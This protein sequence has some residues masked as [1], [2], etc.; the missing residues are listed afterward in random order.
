M[1]ANHYPKEEESLFSFASKVLSESEYPYNSSMKLIQE[2]THYQ[3]FGTRNNEPQLEIRKDESITFYFSTPNQPPL[4][5]LKGIA[6]TFPMLYVVMTYH[7][8]GNELAGY[9]EAF[10]GFINEYPAVTWEEY[11]DVVFGT[12][13]V[14]AMQE[15]TLCPS[16]EKVRVSMEEMKGRPVEGI[17][18]VHCL[19]KSRGESA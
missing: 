3:K 14:Y 11:V 6:K 2:D 4:E 15:D 8:P 5:W 17:V 7:E 12:D 1:S 18:C 13:E 10:K 19:Q 16:C 9:S